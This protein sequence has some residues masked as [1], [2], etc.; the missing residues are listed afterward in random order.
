MKKNIVIGVL[1]L[2]ILIMGGGLVYL[3][4]N[5]ESETDKSNIPSETPTIQDHSEEK[6]EQIGGESDSKEESIGCAKYI[7]AVFYGEAVGDGYEIKET[8]TLKSDGTFVDTYENAGGIPAGTY[9]IENNKITFVYPGSEMTEAHT[10]IN[11]IS[12]DCT[13]IT[14]NSGNI[15]ILNRK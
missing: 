10:S 13:V 3:S 9:A 11:D 5:K 14:R 6:S 8:L 2:I 4:V 7:D 12:D 15:T 1:I